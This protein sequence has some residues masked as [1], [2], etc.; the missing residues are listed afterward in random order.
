MDNCIFCKIIKGDIPCYKIYEDED[1][2]AFLD[3]ANDFEGHTLVISKKHV[4]NIL[5][6][7]E[8]TLAKLIKA[9]KKIAKH[10]VDE[11]GYDGFN[12]FSCN[13]KEAEQGVFHIHFHI[14]P[15]RSSDNLH[16]TPSSSGANVDL[17]KLAKKLRF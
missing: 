2:L 3:I 13:N 4:V 8:E 10:Y 5:D 1:V 16:I 11:C 12:L 7:D 9:T 15:R 14:I 6:A 17:E